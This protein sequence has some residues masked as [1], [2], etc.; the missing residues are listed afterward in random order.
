MQLAKLTPHLKFACRCQVTS[1]SDPGVQT[2]GSEAPLH[3]GMLLNAGYLKV[4]AAPVT[5]QLRCV[6]KDQSPHAHTSFDRRDSR[7]SRLLR[8]T[9]VVF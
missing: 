8:H 4:G 2:V 9:K 5:S 6:A 7:A 3:F 1:R